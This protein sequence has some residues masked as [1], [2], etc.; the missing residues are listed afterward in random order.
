V[1]FCTTKQA[2]HVHLSP[3]ATVAKEKDIFWTGVTS[4]TVRRH[5]HQFLDTKCP[6]KKLYNAS[7]AGYS[8][9]NVVSL[10]LSLILVLSLWF[11]VKCS[12]KVWNPVFCYSIN[13]SK[14]RIVGRQTFWVFWISKVANVPA[15]NCIHKY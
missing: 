3:R 15:I 9:V 4:E 7:P 12:I 5:E 10:I 8:L 13:G 14:K 1:L 6:M 11:V 2:Q